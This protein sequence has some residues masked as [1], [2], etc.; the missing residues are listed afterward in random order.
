MLQRNLGGCAGVWAALRA[1]ATLMWLLV[2]GLFLKWHNANEQ[3]HSIVLQNGRALPRRKFL[4]KFRR[5][6][7]GNHKR[8][9]TPHIFISFFPKCWIHV[10]VRKCAT[11]P[12]PVAVKQSQMEH[13]WRKPNHKR[14]T[15]KE[16]KSQL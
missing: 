13:V 5:H 6:D 11:I 3:S 7:I 8:E 1:S 10:K 16:V 4:V 14:D 2:L 12:T 15:A 9:A